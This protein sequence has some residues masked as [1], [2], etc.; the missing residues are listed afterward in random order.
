MSRSASYGLILLLVFL[1]TANGQSTLTPLELSK[2]IEREL[3]G[4][5]THSYSI[6]LAAGQ[7]ARALV[8][9]RGIDVVVAFR[10]PD[11]QKIVELDT[12]SDD[13][14]AEPVAVLAEIVGTYVLEVTSPASSA[15]KG[16]YE[17]KLEDLRTATP[18][19]RTYITAQQAFTEA[20]PLRNLRTRDSYRRA[21]E[22]YQESLNVWRTLNDV[23]M[24]AYT[25]N[26]MALIL[27][28]I[29]EYQ[30]GL[31]ASAQA[32]TSYT[33]L[34]DWKSA[35][36][37]NINT[38][39]IYNEL[40]ENQKALDLYLQVQEVHRARDKSYV[41]AVLLS[42]IGATYAKLGQYQTALDIHQRV[43]TL[44]RASNS[45]GGQAITLNNM[46]H[47]Y[48]NLGDRSKAL[49]YYLQALNLMPNLRNPF[50]TATTLNHIGENYRDLG[51]HEKALDYFNEAL[52]L[53]QTIGDQNG[54]A[55][56]QSDLARLERNRGTFLDARRRIEAA[57][58]AIE[59]LR[60]KVVS[61]HLRAS[62]FAS[63]QQYREFYIDLLMRLHKQSPAEHFDAAAFE[64][65]ETGRARSLLELLAEAHVEIREG[66]DASLLARER[67]L[68]EAISEVADR[69]GRLF[70]VRHTPEQATAVAREL[71]ALTT[72]YEEVQARIRQT[73]PRYAALTQPVP[74]GIND[75]QKR[76][77]DT[78]TVLLEYSLGEE[79]SFLW[80][81]TPT[82]IKS[83]EL[84]GRATIEASTRVMRDMLLK[85]DP[86]YAQAASAVSG[87][88]LGPVA[89]DIK[90]K[91]L[92]I[93]GDGM[94][95]Y[96][97]FAALPAPSAG[98]SNPLIVNHEIVT[99]PSAAVIAVLREEMT[100]RRVAD[101]TLAVFADPVF[102][103]NDPRVASSHSDATLRSGELPSLRRLRF[104]RQEADEI[105]RFVA[106]DSKIAAVDFAA[107]RALATS[108][109]IGRYRVVHFATHGLINNEHPELS[110][111]VLSLV[112]EKGREQN[113]FLRL[114]GLYN[115]K[116]SAELVVLSACQTALGRE[117]KGEGLVG[118]T[119][120]F[121]Y[122]GAPRVVAT[123]WQ[124]D[125]RASAEM[126]KRFYE[127]MF[128][129]KLSPA[130][131]LGAAQISMHN[132]KRW[133]A[134]YYWA[135]F[136]LQ[137]EWR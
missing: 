78:D 93:V 27:S 129:K 90:N 135:A 111:V 126:M 52:A 12:P 137:G 116:L 101:K 102:S 84:P 134:A 62:L 120:G 56:T 66:V 55:A 35:A 63:V 106:G 41:D 11:G 96:L 53:R 131:A 109:E 113:G 43:L 91:R 105:T 51:Q 54:E 127:G 49:D 34:G 17:V 60:F 125:D 94:L 37:M 95:Q 47:C 22:K 32:H 70:K 80:T 110:G 57:L 83:Y 87:M 33:A 123:L 112:D 50:Y 82:S 2:P 28:D 3:S 76:V 24:K 39:W 114:Y 122:A 115:L 61:Q 119:R 69:Q 73:S 89:E 99:V 6:S 81:V 58:A 121:M 117:I 132:D 19:D 118:L 92:L 103:I 65:S 1:H 98:D 38:A 42:S 30:K 71:A 72:E 20:K 100:H 40:G 59:S 64:A 29:G 130:A 23:Q 97:P 88:L 25:L 67:T 9:Q 48:Q 26:E 7:Y 136:T 74:L 16:R 14:G 133:H 128:E 36:A 5:Q 10:G 77:L 18:Q 13:H 21:L 4:G 68:L 79:K 15:T 107:N 46:A 104:S 44:R 85:R 75:I 108:S 86:G 124:V 31:D 8:V 45:L